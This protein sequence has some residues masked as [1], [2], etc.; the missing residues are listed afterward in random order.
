MTMTGTPLAPMPAPT[1]TRA[2]GAAREFVPHL[3][4]EGLLVIGTIG[5]A[6]ILLLQDQKLPLQ[7]PFAQIATAGFLATAL[8]LSLRTGTV[9]L[10]VAAVAGAAGLGAAT[11]ANHG[12]PFF[13]A[14]AVVVLGGLIVGVIVGAVVGLTRIPGWAASL[15]LLA[16]IETVLTINDDTRGVELRGPSV[17]V[18]WG[19]LWTIAFIIVS[20]AG[21][22][23][24]FLAPVRRAIT[25]E[26]DGD[27]LPMLRRL[28]AAV[29]GFA[30]SCAL[31]ALAGVLMA[32]FDRFVSPSS[33]SLILMYDALGMVLIGGI[34]LLTRRGGFAGTIL[35]VAFVTLFTDWLRVAGAP[36]WLSFWLIPTVAITIGLLISGVLSLITRKTA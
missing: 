17:G 15:W 1:T 23:L 16:A 35:G 32:Q 4:W 27:G 34:G 29:V 11:M 21:G 25:I 28:P 9:N 20:L 12:L 8:A 6:L 22:I 31:A 19:V 24:F 13:V 10:A 7:V 33:G 26:S 36:N 14:G 3:V 2:P 5:V 18:A 30:G